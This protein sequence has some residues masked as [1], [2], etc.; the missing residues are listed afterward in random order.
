MAILSNPSFTA[1]PQGGDVIKV[2]AKV[3]VSFNPFEEYMIKN[4]L[5]VAVSCRMWGE[6]S[7]FNGA[8][9]NLFSM[10]SKRVAADGNVEFVR[11]VAKS[12]LDEDWEGKDEIYA[13][14]G[15][16]SQSPGIIAPISVRSAT[17][18]GR[19]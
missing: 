11:N 1:V 2:T 19:Y 17:K 16:A 5:Q 3:K 18:T 10:G 14:F 7:G 9:D 13:R 4:G 6:D 8:D 15:L 12:W